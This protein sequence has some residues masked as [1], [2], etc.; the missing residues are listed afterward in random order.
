[1]IYEV[2]FK[3]E[4]LDEKDVLLFKDK[5]SVS[6]LNLYIYLENCIK[7][8]NLGFLISRQNYFNNNEENLNYLLFNIKLDVNNLKENKECFNIN[9]KELVKNICSSREYLNE[10]KNILKNVFGLNNI[11]INISCIKIN[12]IRGSREEVLFNTVE[13]RNEK[14]FNELE[15]HKIN[16]KNKALQ[17]RSCK[18]WDIYFI[19]YINNIYIKKVEDNLINLEEKF[20]ELYLSEQLKIYIYKGD[21][22]NIT[23]LILR[24]SLRCIDENDAVEVAEDNNKDMLE[25]IKYAFDK[26]LNI[27]VNDVERKI[28]INKLVEYGVYCNEYNI[29]SYNDIVVREVFD[30][31]EVNNFSRFD[32]YY[33]ND[34]LCFGLHLPYSII[35]EKN[36]CL[37]AMDKKDDENI[38]I[39]I[40][41]FIYKI[42]K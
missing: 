38:F 25:V 8:K 36:M 37:N 15:R 18:L 5:M 32:K 21:T 26:T 35:E 2:I 42:F 22:L 17:R 6:N 3:V 34:L 7:E 40:I 28:N 13:E 19:V 20:N 23:P 29:F 31:N 14:Y 27:L 33:K 1:M 11:L 10:F 41:N 9:D 12:K 16:I 30:G 24:L 4:C 39:R